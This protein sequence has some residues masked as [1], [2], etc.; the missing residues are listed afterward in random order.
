MVL[1]H[2]YGVQ[3]SKIRP[4]D[5]EHISAYAQISNTWPI[6][7]EYI[8]AH[9]L[10]ASIQNTAPYEEHISAYAQVSN[11]WS[12]I[13]NIWK[14]IYVVQVSNIRPLHEKHIQHVYK[15][16]T[17]SPSRYIEAHILR[18]SIQNTASHEGHKSAYVQVSNTWPLHL[19]YT[20]AHILR[21]K[22]PN[23]APP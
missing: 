1:K 19:E 11:T 18:S 12:L 13:Q 10:R 21:T 16:P 6:H 3:L 2:I 14:H 7:S 8:E 20:E 22:F 17:H 5:K 4:V 9:L 23:T 15:Y